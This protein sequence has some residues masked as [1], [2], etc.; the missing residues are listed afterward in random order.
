MSTSLTPK[1][2]RKLFEAFY[3]STMG[4]YIDRDAEALFDKGTVSTLPEG[5]P[6]AATQGRCLVVVLAGCITIGKEWFGPGNHVEIAET[7]AFAFKGQAHLWL[8]DLS[9][10]AWVAPENLALRRATTHALIAADAAEAAATPP[11]ALPDST[12]LCDVD[13]PDIRRRAA[14][15]RRTTPAA[16]AEA[17]MQYVHTLP[18]R[19]GTWQ[20][21]ASD[22]MARGV[23][24]CTTKSNLQVALMRAAGLNAGYVE[25]PM[26]T[27]VLGKLMPHSWI[28]LQRETVKHYFAAVELDG[29]WHAVD[30]SYDRVSYRIF[31]ETFPWM[32]HR[33][34]PTLKVGEPYC[35]ALE[36]Q[37]AADLFDITV[38]PEISAEMGKTSRFLP[39]HFEALNTC[40][41]RAR[42]TQKT[43]GRA[44][45]GVV[46]SSDEAL[47]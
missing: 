10:A 22:T 44:L 26:P 32:A 21:R 37:E 35:P 6:L 27:S 42:G 17:I 45:E 1:L 38:R 28:A 33:E 13:H 31:L 40:V 34:T 11:A 25:I 47:A 23:G 18:Y 4:L 20:E 3:Q 7:A 12:T 41:D 29:T 19:F 14:R 39:R 8:L 43:W 16:T 5:V 36:I 2:N 30:S 15:L 24:M 46:T 9:A